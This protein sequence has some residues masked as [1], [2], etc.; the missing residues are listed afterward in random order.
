ME[1]LIDGRELV[2]P[3]QSKTLRLRLYELDQNSRSVCAGEFELPNPTRRKPPPWKPEPL[4]IRRVDQGVEF[5]LV[6]C[7][8]ENVV[9]PERGFASALNTLTFQI[10][11]QGQSTTNW[12]LRTIYASDALGNHNFYGVYSH[13]DRKGDESWTGTWL[14]WP[15]E[16]WKLRLE[17]ARRGGFAPDELWHLQGIP[18]PGTDSF[19]SKTFQTNLQG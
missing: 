3:R 13:P 12:E 1:T 17:F 9:R 4:P 11:E 14:L 7:S 19:T 5:T 16:P 18:V 6:Q 2:L 10:A 15:D 8:A